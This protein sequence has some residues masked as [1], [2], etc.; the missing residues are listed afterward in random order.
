MVS[1]GGTDQ[2]VEVR[3]ATRLLGTDNDKGCESE[4][5]SQPLC[6]GESHSRIRAAKPVSWIQQEAGQEPIR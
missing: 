3:F 5:D 6:S 2:S 1:P 4:W